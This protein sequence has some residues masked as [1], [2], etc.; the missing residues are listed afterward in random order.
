MRQHLTITLSAPMGAFGAYAGNER[1]GTGIAPGRS[2]ILGLMGAA[3]GVTRDDREG[4]AALRAYRCASRIQQPSGTL[5]DYHT[6]EAVPDKI[7]DPPTRRAA[8]TTAG[9]R[10]QTVIT[11]RDYR[12]DLLVDVAIWAESDPRWPLEAIADAMRQ[13]VF[14]PYLGRK[15]CPLAAPMDPA[16]IEAPN[17]LIALDRREE[18]H[19][20]RPAA[21]DTLT[22]SDSFPGGQPDRIE[23]AP[24]DPIDRGSWHFEQTEVWVFSRENDQ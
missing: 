21:S 11:L 14:T 2:A 15:S 3:L 20:R 19:E 16:L 4:Q 1:R 23:L 18:R 17:P 13:P 24:N 8:L 5:R 6:V 12:T 10:T 7:K 9:T 22:I